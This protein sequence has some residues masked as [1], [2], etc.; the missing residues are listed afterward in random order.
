[1]ALGSAKGARFGS[2]F[3]Q[4][5]IADLKNMTASTKFRAPRWPE[6]SSGGT[7]GGLKKTRGGAFGTSYKVEEWFARP[8]VVN[9]ECMRASPQI[10][11]PIGEVAG[12]LE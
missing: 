5:E 7:E 10:H 9:L 12:C 11:S 8:H 2:G 1:L 4:P 3:A 6:C